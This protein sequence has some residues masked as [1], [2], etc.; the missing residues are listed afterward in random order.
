MT[1]FCV[2]VTGILCINR[3]EGKEVKV[4]KHPEDSA[5][6]RLLFADL[7]IFRNDAEP[8]GESIT[9]RANINRGAFYVLVF[10][11]RCHLNHL[12]PLTLPFI[13]GSHTVE[14]HITCGWRLIN[15]GC[16]VNV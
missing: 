7:H 5:R 9:S 10:K 8:N 12:S 4:F 6:M 16:V 15:Q 14:I 1:Q 11:Y 2:E 3:S 13:I